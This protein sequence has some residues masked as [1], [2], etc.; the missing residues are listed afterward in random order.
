M[1]DHA[2]AGVGST[3]VYGCRGATPSNPQVRPAMLI[4]GDRRDSSAQR[5]AALQSMTMS[6]DTNRTGLGFNEEDYLR[7]PSYER[8]VVFFYDV[9]GW[10][11][12]IAK[13]GDDAEKLG[14]LRRLLIEHSRIIRVPTDGDVRVSTFSDNVVVS[15]PETDPVGPFLKLV[16]TLQILAVS[17]GV[18]VRGG[19]AIGNLIHDR[20]VVFG[21][22]LN[23]AYELESKVAAY[24]RVVIDEDV[25]RRATQVEEFT[26]CE[27]GVC[28][29]DPFNIPFFRFMTQTFTADELAHIQESGVPREEIVTRTAHPDVSLRVVLEKIKPLM[30][31]PLEDKEWTKVA[32]L[33]DR[34]AVRLGRP[35]AASY[36][37]LRPA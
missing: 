5:F 32:W 17:R 4:M 36:P 9:L 16:A 10:R 29:L 11:D 1:A 13:A 25:M 37:R 12:R 30:R 34:I 2:I 26:A 18:L 14:D 20:E 8:R 19:I 33:F 23:R 3:F 27:S 35:L 28:F 15:I 22:G 24:P 21:P 31:E 6:G 7:N